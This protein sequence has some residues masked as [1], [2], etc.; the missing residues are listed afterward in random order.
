MSEEDDE[1]LMTLPTFFT[2]DKHS[3]ADSLNPLN[4][5]VRKD[6]AEEIA[7]IELPSLIYCELEEPSSSTDA[8]SK[9]NTISADTV[10]LMLPDDDINSLQPR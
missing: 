1:I 5:V 4:L 10:D 3:L 8:V 2:D 9:N 6:S 7:D